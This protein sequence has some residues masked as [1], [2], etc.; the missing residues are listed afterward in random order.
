[1]SNHEETVAVL[2]SNRG[3]NKRCPYCGG[4]NFS[5]RPETMVMIDTEHCFLCYTLVCDKCH[6]MSQFGKKKSE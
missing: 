5:T 4:K 3:I 6:H 1:M 2:L